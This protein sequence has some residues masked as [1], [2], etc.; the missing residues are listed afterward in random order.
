MQAESFQ[1]L[2]EK[3]VKPDGHPAG[4]QVFLYYWTQLFGSSAW[5]VKLPFTL[6]GLASVY[7]I[8]LIGKR[9]FNETAGLLSAAFIA[10]IQYTVM[11]SQIARPYISGLF[12][13]LL[14]VYY[15]TRLIQTPDKHVYRNLLMFVVAASLCTYNHHFSLLFAAIAGISGIFLIPKRIRTHYFLAGL[16]IVL[17]YL[18]HLNIFLHQ[19]KAGGVEG[20][21]AKPGNDFLLQYLYYTFNYSW[22]SIGVTSIIV[23]YG[24]L[25]L[26]QHSIKLKLIFLALAWFMIP[27]LTGFFYSRYVNAVLQFSV[28]IFSFPFL[29]LFLFG[30]IKKQTKTINL[31]LVAIILIANTTS[32]VFGREHYDIFYDSIYKKVLTDYDV[33][34]P[35]KK[36]QTL[37]IIDS[38]REITDFYLNELDIDTNI[39]LFNERFKTISS[40]KSYLEK[41]SNTHEQL[42]F[43][44]LVS[45]PANVIPLIQDYYPCKAVENYYFKGQTYVFRQSCNRSDSL[46]TNLTFNSP[47]PDGW[48]SIDKKLILPAK[49]NPDEFLYSMPEDK[50]WGPSYSV[51]ADEV[52]HNSNNFLDVSVDARSMAHMSGIKLVAELKNKGSE[53]ALYWGATD[54]SDF[55]VSCDSCKSWQRIHH[56]VKLSDARL[57]GDEL[58]LK[59]YIW[60]KSRKAIDLNNVTIRL[61]EG[62]P[63][64]YGLIEKL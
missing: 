18:P 36:A 53:K 60:N 5:V 20:W 26:R 58:L 7:L 40:L 28:L 39:T 23:L 25:Q 62:N 57:K 31:V 41:A 12:F 13:S 33:I 16:V 61:R 6:F 59:V 24:L 51:P 22:L 21:L 64:V 37:V 46:I 32:L 42:Y 2:I 43:G 55:D 63:R 35:E 29:L 17:L 44:C 4:I 56:S 45:I 50:V 30:F 38:D 27:F 19:L 34:K 49:G 1:E 15:L 48:Q 8:Y 47:L 3:G 54:F 14:M 9:W 52:I 10:S 11:Y